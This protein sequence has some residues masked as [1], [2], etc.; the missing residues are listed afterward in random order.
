[1]NS[2]FNKIDWC[3]GKNNSSK[4]LVRITV[5]V[6]DKYV[7]LNEE[8][9]SIIA[10]PYHD[11]WL[12]GNFDDRATELDSG[13]VRIEWKVRMSKNSTVR[14][15]L[16]TIS[17]LPSYGYFEGLS[18]QHFDGNRRLLETVFEVKCGT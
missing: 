10:Y 9:W 11:W 16:E 1:M 6:E 8:D 18:Q 2:I 15:V 12:S 17:K 14:N 4:A 3:I 5:G 13:D 7:P